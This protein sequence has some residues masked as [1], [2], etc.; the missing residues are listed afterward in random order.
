LEVIPCCVDRARFAAHDDRDA[1]RE[2]FGL[3]G[4]LVFIYVGA[5]GGYYLTREN[6]EMMAAARAQDRRV[7]A[8]VLTQS[9]PEGMI[10]E[11]QRLGFSSDDYRVITVAPDDVPRYLRAADV[12]L[13]LVRPSYARRSM[14][15]TKFAE[16]LGAGLP[17]IATAGIGDLDQHIEESGTGVLLQRLDVEAYAAAFRAIEELRRDPDLAERCRREARARYDLHD[18]GGTRYLRLYAAVLGA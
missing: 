1:I 13:S 12:A 4:R 5:L 3:A 17:V 7:Y 2:N 8:L 16:Y 18:V 9:S 14:S 11:L 6:A 15:P 10:V